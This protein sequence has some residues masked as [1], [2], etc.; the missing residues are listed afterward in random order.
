MEHAVYGGAAAAALYPALGGA[1]SLCFWGASVLI[2]IDHYIDFVYHNGFTDLSVRKMFDYHA[3]LMRWWRK[4]QFLNIEVFHT[5]EFMAP[6]CLLAWR[7]GSG[8]LMAA[9]LGF[10][11]HIVLDAASLAL[12]GVPFIRAHSFV[13]YF[14][15]KRA[16]GRQGLNPAELCREAV[17]LIN[18]GD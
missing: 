2:D 17:R 12:A 7:T 14:L 5:I 13:E 10:A 16:L 8:A 6:L 3:V 18:Q 9:S 4:P 15:R 11:F 1:G